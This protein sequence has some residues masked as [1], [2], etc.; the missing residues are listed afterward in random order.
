MTPLNLLRATAIL[1]GGPHGKARAATLRRK[2]V[3]VPAR[4][5]CPQRRP[6]LHLPRHWPWSEAWLM[7]SDTTI[8]Y[9]P[10]RSATV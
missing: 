3:N 2:L 9:A 7:L 8:G 5:A 6:I 4:L 1:A 10:P